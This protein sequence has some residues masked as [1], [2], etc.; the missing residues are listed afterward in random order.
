MTYDKAVNSETKKKKIL[1]QE[2]KNHNKAFRK[3]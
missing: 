2:L 1:I 3:V